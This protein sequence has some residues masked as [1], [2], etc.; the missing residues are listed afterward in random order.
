MSEKVMRA[1]R[2]DNCGTIR[3]KKHVRCPKCRKKEF[4]EV[5]LEEGRLL[6]FTKLKAIPE[7]VERSTLVLGIVEFLNG[8]KAMGQIESEEPEIGMKLIPKHAKLRRIQGQEV[9]GFTFKAVQ[10]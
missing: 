2:C 3:L 4:Q 6:S 10:K 5:T 8:A 1:F 9:F 7:G